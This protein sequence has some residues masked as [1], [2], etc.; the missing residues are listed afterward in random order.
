MLQRVRNA[1][2]VRL[3]LLLS[4]V[5]TMSACGSLS[6][7][8]PVVTTS[9]PAIA[10]LA[11][12]APVTIP[13]S[14][15]TCV[16]AQAPISTNTPTP[17][18]RTLSFQD[19]PLHGA[20]VLH[21]QQR[22]S[23]LGY[24]EVGAL[25][26]IF[27]AQTQAAV[28]H[29][30]HL[31]RLPADGIVDAVTRERLWSEQ[32]VRYVLPLPFPGHD[33]SI[34]STLLLCDDQFLHFRL[35]SL[36]YLTPGGP[37]WESGAYRTQTQSA[38][39]RFQS[40][41]GLEANGIVNLRTWG[42]LFSPLAV[43]AT[44]VITALPPALNW[45]TTVFAVGAHPAAL[46]YDGRRMWV[47]HTDAQDPY[48]N[49]V[50]AIDPETGEMGVPIRV[51][52]CPAETPGDTADN[53]VFDGQRLWVLLGKLGSVQSI[54]PDTGWTAPPL[55]L[56]ACPECMTGAALA[57]D[58]VHKQ[59]WA[60][61]GDDTVR[62]VDVATARVV[63]SQTVGWL[64]RYMLFDGAWMWV[65]TDEGAITA[66]DPV[67][68]KYRDTYVDVPPGP[69]ASDGARL[70]IA[71]WAVMAYDLATNEVVH[72]IETGG[73]ASALAYDGKLV[74]M[75]NADLDTV[76][77]IDPDSGEIEQTISVGSRP[78]ALA[79]DGR[80]LWVANNGSGTVQYIA[81]YP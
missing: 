43:T 80:R 68:G 3:A 38:V 13:A 47:L 69:M 62:A 37:E 15:P 54:E 61:A 29:F 59:V 24:A 63:M 51:G 28:Q 53:L 16:P 17:V 19:P 56:G 79:F 41:N 20:D 22:M 58:P 30:Q 4:A 76:Q 46:A 40:A 21:V 42:Q 18:A 36:G 25:D 39:Q 81:L 72:T 1:G 65:G 67:T 5:W 75:A 52:R 11:T 7:P 48:G 45:H 77:A 23:D 35:A 10:T 2:L 73:A 44:A 8:T 27:G 71:A 12:V 32:A 50:L 26:G 78:A 60:A 49:M 55:N 34:N 64:P 74:W 31:N 9:I 70:W 14:Q 57:Y 33:L 66:F 6:A